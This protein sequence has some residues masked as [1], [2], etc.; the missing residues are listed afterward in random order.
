MKMG[1]LPQATFWLPAL[2]TILL[3]M[4]I[5]TV[6]QVWFQANHR[7]THA[8]ILPGIV[9]MARA[10]SFAVVFFADGGMLAS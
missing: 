7:V 4:T 9:D 10:I 1:A 2:A 5:S 8:V 3:P 6:M